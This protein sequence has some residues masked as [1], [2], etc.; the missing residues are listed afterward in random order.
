MLS[1]VP[2]FFADTALLL[3]RRILKVSA[4][5]LGV[6]SAIHVAAILAAAALPL[7]RW[8]GNRLYDGIVFHFRIHEVLAQ[9][10]PFEGEFEV[11][12]DG[13]SAAVTASYYR[14]KYVFVFGEASSHARHDDFVTDFR[15]LAGRNILVLR[16]SAPEDAQ[17]R[18]YFDAVEYR[19]FD[20]AG[21][22][23]H[24]VLGRGFRYEAYRDQILRSMRDRYYAMPR[25]LPKGHCDFCERY[26]EGASC[27]VR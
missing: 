2:F 10:K 24:V 5:F 15:K 7:E 3:P 16:K 21:A 8:Q 20:V 25:Y 12:A 4:V 26:F 11:A 6:F 19:S 13:Y 23:F 9:L 14:G 17:Y 1:F 22:T 18:P 27:P